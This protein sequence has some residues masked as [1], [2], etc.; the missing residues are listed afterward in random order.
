MPFFLVLIRFC[1]N[2]RSR[3]FAGRYNDKAKKNEIRAAGARDEGL[4]YNVYSLKMIDNNAPAL[5]TE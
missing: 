1:N 2:N 3:R 5:S 4:E